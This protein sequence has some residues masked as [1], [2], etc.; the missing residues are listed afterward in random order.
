MNGSIQPKRAFLT[1]ASGFV[2]KHLVTYLR[3]QG[4]QVCALVRSDQAAHKVA[5]LGVEV[6][7]GN[8]DDVQR[9][10]VG[11]SGCDVVFHLAARA[12]LWGP[13][14]DFYRVNVLGTQNVVKA[15]RAAGVPRVV[16][17]STEAVLAGSP[18]RNV[19]E[20]QARPAHPPGNY[21]ISKGLAEEIVLAANSQELATVIVRP[22]S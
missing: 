14:A 8:L 13:Y 18:I 4:I 5:Q 2:G 7:R 22:H 3:R 11:M 16:H 20:T 6:R 19:D 15:A 21:A 12:S 1:G 17:V 10:E 9:M